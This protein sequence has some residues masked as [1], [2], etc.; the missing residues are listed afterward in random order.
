MKD[1]DRVYTYSDYIN[2]PDDERWEIIDGVPFRMEAPLWEHQA[3]SGELSR[4]I[5]NQLI[6]LRSPCMVFA[7]PFDL[8]LPYKNERDDDISTVVQPDILIICNKSNLKGT[9]YT[10]VPDFII[11]IL[12]DSTAKYDMIKKLDK[13]EKSGIKEYWIVDPD[14][15]RVFVF[16]LNNGVYG[17]PDFYFENDKIKLKALENIEIDLELVFNSIKI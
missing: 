2:F 17:K 4:Q 12:S 8:R 3:I 9:G 14:K 13:Y 1:L 5:S 7:A 11:E 16:V 10:G 15:K 6:E